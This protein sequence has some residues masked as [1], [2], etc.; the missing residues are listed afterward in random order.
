MY[1]ILE[2]LMILEAKVHSALGNAAHENWCEH[3][4]ILKNATKGKSR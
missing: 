1:V 4:K 2:P 3:I